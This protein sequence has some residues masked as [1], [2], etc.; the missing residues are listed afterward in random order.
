MTNCGSKVPK[1]IE[2]SQ[3]ACVEKLESFQFAV[4]A[5]DL[6]ASPDP[7]DTFAKNLYEV[8]ANSFGFF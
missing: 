4:H 7:A 3:M 1:G 6:V 8:A 2:V 5:P